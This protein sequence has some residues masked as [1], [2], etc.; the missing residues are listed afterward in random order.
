MERPRDI[1]IRIISCDLPDEIHGASLPTNGGVLIMV[2]HK[3]SEDRQAAAFLHEM[4]HVW[5]RDHAKTGANVH[6]I[7]ED[8]REEMRRLFAF[9]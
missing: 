8:C 7:E 6:E 9:L 2:N 1:S 3:D 5:R 4:L